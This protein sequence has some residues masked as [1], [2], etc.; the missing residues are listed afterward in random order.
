MNLK[1]RA[2]F[3]DRADVVEN[4]VADE[5]AEVVPYDYLAVVQGRMHVLANYAI[6]NVKGARAYYSRRILHNND[7]ETF[8]RIL[9]SRLLAL[10]NGSVFI[11]EERLFRGRDHMTKLLEYTT[12]FNLAMICLSEYMERKEAHWRRLLAERG[13]ENSTSSPSSLSSDMA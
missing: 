5:R 12:G 7:G 1:G 2:I 6:L 8:I 4:A 10:N 13:F 9:E 11:F 3:Q